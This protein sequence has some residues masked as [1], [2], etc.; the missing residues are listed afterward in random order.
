MRCSEILLLM[1]LCVFFLLLL[2]FVVSLIL[3]SYA[4][5]FPETFPDITVGGPSSSP[6][7]SSSVVSLP[8]EIVPPSD[9]PSDYLP[10]DEFF[11]RF[12]DDYSVSVIGVQTV[13][14]TPITSSSGFKGI[15]LSLMGPYDPTI[16]QFRYQSNTSTNYTYVNDISPDFPW[17]VS[18][19][20][21]AIVLYCTF[22]LGGTLFC[23]I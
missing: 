5:T 4:V 8:P 10:P 6:D 16:T 11:D 19:A 15:I 18:A 20:I 1:L 12:G 22:K 7:D 23:K 9:S 13:P 2:L 17:L 3:P 21:F 14:N